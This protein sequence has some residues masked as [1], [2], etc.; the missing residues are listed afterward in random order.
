[1]QQIGGVGSRD[2]RLELPTQQHDVSRR[3]RVDEIDMGG[4]E[5]W[6]AKNRAAAA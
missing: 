6:A 2:R 5:T 3:H 1:V 4:E